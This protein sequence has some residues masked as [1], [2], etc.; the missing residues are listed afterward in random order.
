MVQQRAGV[1]IGPLSI[2]TL[3]SV[4]LIATFS[5]LCITTANATYTMAERQ[6]INTTETYQLDACGQKLLAAVNAQ[7]A[8]CTSATEAT[9]TISENLDAL[10]QQAIQTTD[11][12][13]ITLDAHVNNT[14]I[15]FTA[16][17]PSGK[18]LNGIIALSNNGTASVSE[19]KFSVTQQPNEETLWSGSFENK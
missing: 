13:A 19:W 1:R 17:M 6:A 10:E 14:T 15:A 9:K 5:V 12:E 2:A 3:I 7:I 8:N 11:D 4:L 18:T 16:T